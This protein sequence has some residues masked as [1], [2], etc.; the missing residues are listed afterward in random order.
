M[1]VALTPQTIRGTTLPIYVQPH[2][3]MHHT[4]SGWGASRISN[5]AA[6]STN[7]DLFV[8][9]AK[10]EIKFACHSPVTFQDVQLMLGCVP[11]PSDILPTFLFTILFSGATITGGSMLPLRASDAAFWS[12]W[13]SWDLGWG[14]GLGEVGLSLGPVVL[15]AKELLQGW[16]RQTDQVLGTRERS[17]VP[18]FVAGTPLVAKMFPHL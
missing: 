11:L 5:V 3:S 16:G 12:C 17:H 1:G 8:A 15:Q 7:L 14:L 13:C 18:L 4:S 6:L 10:V 9:I 2:T